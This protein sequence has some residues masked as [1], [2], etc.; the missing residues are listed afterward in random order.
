MKQCG[1]GYYMDVRQDINGNTGLI[2][3]YK[4]VPNAELRVVSTV[5]AI[6]NT[7]KI[8]SPYYLDTVKGFIPISEKIDITQ[9]GIAKFFKS[10]KA[11]YGVLGTFLAIAEAKVKYSLSTEELVTFD[12]QF[13]LP[14]TLLPRLDGH[15]DNKG[16]DIPVLIMQK[17]ADK[18]SF[19]TRA[20][21]PN[22]IKIFESKVLG[23][24][25]YDVVKTREAYINARLKN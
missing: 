2:E 18:D 15:T 23:F 17:C 19:L 10:H 9:D 25:T 24:L 20:I 12:V 6:D 11:L 14:K 13:Y 21:N 1:Y 5:F 4:I 16:N 22:L 7:G 3:S 8:L